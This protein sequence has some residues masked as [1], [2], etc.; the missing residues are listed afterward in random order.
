MS[1]LSQSIADLRKNYTLQSLDIEDADKDP[2]KQFKHWFD[3]ALKAEIPEPNAMVL[4]TAAQ[5]GQPSA[6][7]VL[8]KG[9]D[10]RGFIFYTNYSS[11][12]GKQ[13]A[14][15]P[16]ASLCFN[17]LELERQVRIEGRAERLSQEESDA[18]FQSRPFESRIGALA[19]AQSSEVSGRAALEQRFATLVDEFSGKAVPKPDHWGGYVLAPQ[20]IEF[21]QGRPGRLHD[22]IEYNKQ[23]DGSWLNRRLCP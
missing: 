6:R 3:E 5:D 21:W 18:Y 9:F 14:E 16:L 20:L 8:L 13:L 12:K 17:W 11:R 10:E 2:F 22:R 23:E 7:V 15:N 4:A 19:S 1:S